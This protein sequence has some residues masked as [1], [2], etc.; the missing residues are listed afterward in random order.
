VSNFHEKAIYK[1]ENNFVISSPDVWYLKDTNGDGRADLRVKVLTGFKGE[2][3]EIA[4]TLR[5]GL[6]NKFYGSASYAGGKIR[7]L[8]NSNAPA[9]GL[10]QR[11]WSFDPRNGALAAVSGTG[12]FGHSFDDWG[13]R[14]TCNA[15]A[16]YIHGVLAA[17]YLARN[18]F[19][20]SPDPSESAFRGFP[21]VFAI[22]EPEPWRIVRQ[23]F[24]KRWVNTTPD[25]NVGRFPEN[26]LA[27]RGHLTS[28][29]GLTVYR[30]SAFPAAYSGNAFLGEP[31]N[32]VVI[33]LALEPDGVGI[34]PIR[35][36]AENNR[37]FLA[38]TDV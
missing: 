33:R 10:R 14:F 22:S 29:S 4:N 31:A 8:A 25:M 27:G 6:V 28:G 34:K 23:K 5:W 18:P 12:E 13:N 21:D 16:M 24:W 1:T 2:T 32:N 3:Y 19:F 37:E 30:G 20:P 17:E 35:A 7:W 38:S 26:E 36:G 9:I 15:N 11:D